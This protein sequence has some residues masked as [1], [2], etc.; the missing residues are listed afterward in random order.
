ML[1]ESLS[2]PR[3]LR[4][5]IQPNH[6]GSAMRKFIYGGDTETLRGAPM[7]FQFYSEA[8]KV[9]DILWIDPNH[10]TRTT[11]AWCRSLAAKAQHV[12]Y[13]HNLEF[14]LVSFFWD[15]KEKMV[16]NTDGEFN[17]GV[18]GWNISGVYGSP[19]YCRI[20]DHGNTRSILLVDSFSYYRATLKKAATV[21]CPHLPK[22]RRPQGLGE[23]K[24]TKRDAGFIDY[25]MRDAVVAY[26]IGVSLEA[27]HDEFDLTQTVSVADMAARIFRHRFL[28]RAIPQPDRPIIEAALN[29]YH[30]GKNNITVP[31]GWY[32]DVTSLDISS[33]Y[34]DAMASF[35]SMS[36]DK[37]YRKFKG[38]RVKSVPD[39]GVYRV[40][41]YA[42]ECKW[43]ALFAHDFTPLA[44]R[45]DG[46][47]VSGYELN[48]AL[49]SGEFRPV[50]VTGWYYDVNRDRHAPPLHAFVHDFY[51]RKESEKD[52]PKRQMYKFILN[53][54]SGKFI[55]TR[56]K[57]KIAHVDIDSGHVSTAGDLVAGGMF[58]PF[59][60][61]AI[62]GHT[63]TRIH[64]LEH[65]YKAIHTATD[66]IFTQAKRVRGEGKGLGALVCEA[67][68]DLLLIRNKCYVLY[69][70]EGDTPSVVF[71]G[72]RIIKHA[73]HGFRGTVTELERLVATG[74][75]KYK[76]LVANRLRES[77]RRG[78]TP[79][80]F[81][82]RDYTLKVGAL[83]VHTGR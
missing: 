24:F 27:L 40:R 14:D 17:F 2:I 1:Y 69:G 42:A 55:Q 3:W 68:G 59:I 28:E 56:K 57:Q 70:P 71:K 52:P 62:T 51:K 74:R 83:K 80:E 50:N 6:K 44:G 31:A 73:M 49:R 82:T 61:Q 36:E 46:V 58:H 48:E 64:Q 72:K 29:A 7:T 77:V 78:L 22:L 13:V 30:G 35:P 33:A 21:F 10:A 66:G 41:G 45:V 23:K 19:T 39:L 63:R 34:P 25:A 76:T 20:S 67:K 15:H 8:P 32:T 16:L 75:R 5:G 43:P 81:L 4:D 65:K 60:A 37:A 11:L 26:H 12:V 9:A 47:C 38:D 18:A 54:I 79:N 53:A